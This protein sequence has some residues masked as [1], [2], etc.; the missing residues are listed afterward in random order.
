[1]GNILELLAANLLECF[2][3]GRQLFVNLD[4][5]LGHDLVRF[6]GPANQSEVRAC[7]DSFVPIR[8]KTYPYQDRFPTAILL[9]RRVRHARNLR[10]EF[11][12]V[13]LGRGA[14]GLYQPL[15]P[16]LVIVG[17]NRIR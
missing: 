5:L 13:K 2:A 9:A 8:I 7:R 3:F 6:L 14:L 11:L 4:D 16:N 15:T 17:V 1:M 12:M 10:N